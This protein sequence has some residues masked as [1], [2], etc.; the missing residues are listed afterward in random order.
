MKKKLLT[1][2]LTVFMLP[3]LGTKTAN[4]FIEKVY[5]APDRASVVPSG[6]AFG[7]AE[8]SSSRDKSSVVPGYSQE[9]QPNSF[10]SE[11]T[12]LFEEKKSTNNIQAL[13]AGLSMVASMI[14]FEQSTSNNQ[15]LVAALGLGASMIL[16]GKSCNKK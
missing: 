3:M 13:V 1:L 2:T 8:A 7:N 11:D 16:L 9:I 6:A 10:V 5:V 4:A 15:A 12:P 14:L